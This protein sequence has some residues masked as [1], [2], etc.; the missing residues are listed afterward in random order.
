MEI[1][2]I[3]HDGSSVFRTVLRHGEPPTVAALRCGS[4]MI[5]PVEAVRGDEEIELTLLVESA[6]GQAP[7]PAPVP[8]RDVDLRLTDGEE[9][10]VFQRIAAYAVVTSDRGL[11]AT[12]YSDRVV[13][14]GR[15]GLPGGGID[16]HEQPVDAVLREVH[17]ETAQAVEV[18]TLVAVHS[19]HWIGR[20]PRGDVEDFHAVRLIYTATCA[21]PGDPEV[22]DVGGTTESA[23][24]V[25]LDDWRSVGW[26]SGWKDV[27]RPVLAELSATGTAVTS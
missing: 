17:E 10:R 6:G 26:T 25:A 19:G 12:E 22:I 16:P 8:H 9:P 24:W 23:R 21:T 4:R 3:D 14:A 15:Y 20:S 5:R 7:P 1:I 18:T 13:A 27:I 2:G 11:L